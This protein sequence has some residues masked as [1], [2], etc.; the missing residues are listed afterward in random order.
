MADGDYAKKYSRPYPQ[1][2]RYRRMAKQMVDAR[3]VAGKSGG[4]VGGAMQTDP[5]AAG[6]E[7]GVFRYAEQMPWLESRGAASVLWADTAE[8]VFA[9]LTLGVR[10]QTPS[11]IAPFAGLGG[12]VS[13]TPYFEYVDADFDNIDNDDD[14]WIDEP[15]EQ[16]KEFEYFAAIYP[17]VGVHLWATPRLRITGSAAYMLTS[18]GRDSDFWFFGLNIARLRLRSERDWNIELPEDSPD[19]YAG[20]FGEDEEPLYRLPTP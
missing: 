13:I 9:G 10:T 18:Q 14:D 2:E 12:H 8:E 3:H 11:R 1:G 16:R 19:L 7:V 20:E 6:V 4:Y 17:E 15:G 5:G